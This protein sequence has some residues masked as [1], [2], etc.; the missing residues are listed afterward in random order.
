[1]PLSRLCHHIGE[2]TATAATAI[3]G[4]IPPKGDNYK[5]K[6]T[7]AVYTPAATAHDLIIMKAL[8]RTTVLTSAVDG[9]TTLVLPDGANGDE[10]LNGEALASGDYIIVKYDDGF[11]G[12]LAVSA[13][14][15]GS[16][17]VG[18]LAQPITAGAPVWLMGAPGQAGTPAIHL[19]YKCV[20]STRMVFGDAEAGC[21]E[22]GFETVVSNTYYSR[23]GFGDPLMLY[24]ANGTNA[25]FLNE[26]CATYHRLPQN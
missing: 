9:A 7:K 16:L 3:T 23:S 20:A 4:L 19:T 24:S 14:T 17:T 15:A 22:S 1:M 18:A 10:F 12:I 13:N 6:I 25:G 2:T 26:V 5:T 8:A 21:A 11:Y